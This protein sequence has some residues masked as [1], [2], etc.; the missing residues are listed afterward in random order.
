[1]SEA[2]PLA[3]KIVESQRAWGTFGTVGDTSK[4][5]PANTI[6]ASAAPAEWRAGIDRT[7]ENG[8]LEM[9]ESGTS[10]R[11]IQTGKDL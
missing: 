10:Y 9:N 5:Q 1:M 11:F 7:I 8:W 4:A 2:A 3:R 6:R